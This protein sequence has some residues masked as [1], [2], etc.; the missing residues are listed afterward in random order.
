MHDNNREQYNIRPTAKKQLL[1][2]AV[3]V[4]FQLFIK[5]GVNVGFKF[6]CLKVNA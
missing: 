6:F 1:K 2:V 4:I 5:F 3:T